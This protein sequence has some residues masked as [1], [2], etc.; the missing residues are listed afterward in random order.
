MHYTHH[1]PELDAKL[2]K[3]VTHTC[4]HLH[5]IYYSVHDNVYPIYTFN[6]SSDGIE[7]GYFVGC[8]RVAPEDVVLWINAHTTVGKILLPFTVDSIRIGRK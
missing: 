6:I 7:A 5:I 8:R 2:E 1:I 4:M 3:V